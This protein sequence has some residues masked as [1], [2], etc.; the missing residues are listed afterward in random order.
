MGN[1]EKQKQKYFRKHNRTDPPEVI[2]NKIK[3]HLK[4][5]S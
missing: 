4:P 3:G 2:F 5:K 1:M